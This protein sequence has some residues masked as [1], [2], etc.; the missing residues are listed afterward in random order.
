[1]CRA[2]VL[3][4]AIAA[5][6][7]GCKK[8]FEDIT[9]GGVPNDT[10]L[11]G[12]GT[13]PPDV[14]CSN[15]DGVCLFGCAGNDTDCNAVCGDGTC[16]GNAGEL[17]NTCANDCK[18]TNTVCGNGDCEVGEPE[19]QCYADCGPVPWQ[20]TAEEAQL[21]QLINQKRTGGFKCPG[22]PGGAV[23][24]PALA[25][26]PALELGAR[27]WA[28]EVAHQNFWMQDGS[29]CNGRDA[30]M[31]EAE[32]GFVDYISSFGFADVQAAFDDW[33]VA[34]STCTVLMS[35]VR[36]KMFVA[37]AFD[38]QKGYIFVLK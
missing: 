17:C 29:A 2:L 18:T 3:L 9:D 35:A 6:A 11:L 5:T 21:I 20:W 34:G 28:W 36:T 13:P 38:L 19:A 33:L 26:D 1:M 15:G 27:G 23:T 4:A 37:V 10:I 31:R 7:A 16:I 25:I 14:T 24:V 12:D 30:T 32:G 8:N 22:T